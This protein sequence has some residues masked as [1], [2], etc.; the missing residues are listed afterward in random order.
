MGE[1]LIDESGNAMR[2]DAYSIR[3]RGIPE[4]WRMATT[5]ERAM[6]LQIAELRERV[7]ALESQLNDAADRAFEADLR[8]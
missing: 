5:I 3:E 1:V 8:N 7:E 6:F 2:V 4:G